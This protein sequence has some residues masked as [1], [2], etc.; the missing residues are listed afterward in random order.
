MKKKERLGNCA[1]SFREERRTFG[2]LALW[3]LVD[4]A[5]DANNANLCPL[6]RASSTSIS[7]HAN[8][9]STCTFGQ[10]Q[11]SASDAAAEQQQSSSGKRKS[12]SRSTAGTM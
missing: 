3:G 12:K 8:S 4:F 5:L 6:Q 11:S 1:Q 9:D 7:F 10:A 2:S